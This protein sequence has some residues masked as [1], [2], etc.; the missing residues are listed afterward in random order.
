MSSATTDTLHMNSAI[1]PLLQESSTVQA[2]N[3]K[4]DIKIDEDAGTEA[5]AHA[6]LTDLPVVQSSDRLDALESDNIPVFPAE[7]QGGAQTNGTADQ[8]RSLS[9]HTAGHTVPQDQENEKS[10]KGSSHTG[11]GADFFLVKIWQYVCIVSVR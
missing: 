6:Q 5:T 7:K 3:Y 1:H 11:K 9:M 8:P 10:K 2:E 4:T